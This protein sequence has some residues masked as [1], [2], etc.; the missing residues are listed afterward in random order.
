MYGQQRVLAQLAVGGDLVAA[1]VAEE[2]VALEAA[3]R[4]RALLAA[5]AGDGDG[6]G[7]AGRAARVVLLGV[8]LIVVAGVGGVLTADADGVLQGAAGRQRPDVVG[9]GGGGGGGGPGLQAGGLVHVL[10]QVAYDVRHSQR[11]LLLV[12]AVGGGAG[13]RRGG[14]R[15]AGG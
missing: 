3:G 11:L 5:E 10:E 14:R 2:V 12:G 8:V 4:G 6:G 7:G 15:Q 9:H 13:R 1:L